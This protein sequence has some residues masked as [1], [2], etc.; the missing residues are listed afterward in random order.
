MKNSGLGSIRVVYSEGQETGAIA[1][2][3]EN[4]RKNFLSGVKKIFFC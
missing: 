2:A 4:G 3:P 1:P